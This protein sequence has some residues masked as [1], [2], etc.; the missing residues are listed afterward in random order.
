MKNKLLYSFF[1]CYSMVHLGC[2]KEQDFE[3][4][5]V[6]FILVDDLGYSDL[7][8]T[9]S[10]SYETPNI[11]ALASDGMVFTNAY[12]A[13]P[14]CSPTRAAILTGKYPARINITDYIP[15]NRHWGPH[16]DQKLASQPF[17][18]QLDLEEYTMAE[19][20][21]AEGYKTLFAGKWHLGEQDEFYPTHQ[22]FDINIG[23]N[24]TGHPSGGY[25]S[26]YQNPELQDGL[27]GE[28][29]TDRLTNE[30]IKFIEN[31]KE[32]PFFAY[33]SFYS[34][35]L[36]LQAKMDKVNKYNEK[37]AKQFNDKEQ[38]LKEGETF[39][40]NRQNNAKYAGMVESMDDN[41][42]RVLQVLKKNKILKNTI[43]VFTSDNGGMAS[44]N[45]VDN[46]PT[47]NL[48]LRAGKGHLYEG[49][50]HEPLI[51]KWTNQIKAG[52]VSKSVV[53]STDLYPTLLDLAGI[54]QLPQQHMDGVSLKPILLG[55]LQNDRPVFWH[56]PHYSGG[57]GGTPSGA[58]RMGDYKLIE[59]YE[60][61]HIELYNI[62]N[63]VGEMNNLAQEQ[64]SKVMELKKILHQ[65]RKD[66][67][68]L[69][70]YPN[71]HYEL[72]LPVSE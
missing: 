38:F 63:D 16:A 48:P 58:I 68:A 37:F 50:I 28:Y 25:F 20:F 44:S 1:V 36:P 51:L 71:P 2:Q 69:M 23:G 7:G 53:T 26:P 21:K 55:K 22:G 61:M 70:P 40:K 60:D 41:V 3:R 30:V 27:K 29:L 10:T 62:V 18:L 31:T 66:M 34:V 46:I 19:A 43:I 59:F 72:I 54:G 14:V 8:Y 39:F 64:P 24:K 4:P 42:G 52:S 45:T 33:L 11:D 35:H 57:L 47:T 5:N 56:T 15:G 32:G 6:L 49:G 9:G 12:A 17:K 13:S 65:W 67:N